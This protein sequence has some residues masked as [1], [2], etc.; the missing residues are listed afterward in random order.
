MPDNYYIEDIWHDSPLTDDERKAFR[1]QIRQLILGIKENTHIDLGHSAIGAID[2]N[3]FRDESDVS[4]TV[5]L[6]P[7]ELET[8]PAGDESF[9]DEGEDPD[10]DEAHYLRDLGHEWAALE[11][12][13]ISEL[14]LMLDLP[15]VPVELSDY[16]L[17]GEEHG[18]CLFCTSSGPSQ[19]CFSITAHIPEITQRIYDNAEFEL[20]RRLNIPIDGS[21]K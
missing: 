6:K 15:E 16:L 1:D 17:I 14:V 8:K 20:A 2:F 7:D 12:D 4:I 11:Y 21:D 10:A 18:P 13:I 9:W 5:Y 19:A 3:S